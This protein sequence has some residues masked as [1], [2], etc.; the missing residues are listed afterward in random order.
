M[1]L[2]RHGCPAR[3][4]GSKFWL[5]RVALSIAH[6]LAAW[7]VVLRFGLLIQ[8]VLQLVAGV[9]PRVVAKEGTSTQHTKEGSVPQGIENATCVEQH[10]CL[11]VW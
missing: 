6:L 4:P 11:A 5:N 9:A 1:L 8:H 2:P 7:E 10:D 3:L